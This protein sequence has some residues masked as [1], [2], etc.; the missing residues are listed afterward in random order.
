[1]V[2]FAVGMEGDVPVNNGTVTFAVGITNVVVDFI[3]LGL[4]LPILWGLQMSGRKKFLLFLLLGAGSSM[5][6]TDWLML[7]S[8]YRVAATHS[9][10]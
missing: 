4:P 6:M 1:M 10:M 7:R 2:E 9:L 5:S 8:M 3:L